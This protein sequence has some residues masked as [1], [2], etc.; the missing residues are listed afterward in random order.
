MES[1]V[2]IRILSENNKIYSE[3]AKICKEDLYDPLNPTTSDKEEEIKI[4]EANI[5]QENGKI[6]PKGDNQI[7]DEKDGRKEEITSSKRSR[8]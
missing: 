5:Q 7:K 3:Q 4:K 6:T 1:E 8:R 2:Q